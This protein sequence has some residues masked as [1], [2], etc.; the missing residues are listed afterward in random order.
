MLSLKATLQKVDKSVGLLT[1]EGTYRLRRGPKAMLDRRIMAAFG[2]AQETAKKLSKSAA[3]AATL[4]AKAEA[5]AGANEE[6]FNRSK[7]EF[8]ALIRMLKAWANRSYTDIPWNTL[9]SA[10][11]AMVYFVNPLDIIPDFLAGPGL[12]DD[13]AV[14][15]FVIS[16]IRVE[17][18]KFREWEKKAS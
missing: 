3:A 15:T 5:K 2:R 7:D 10:L 12:I 14:I 17:I 4:I 18:T 9:V 1:F 8:F 11:G 6:F 16:S 13:L